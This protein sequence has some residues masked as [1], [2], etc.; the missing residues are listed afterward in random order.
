LE[1][2]PQ[3]IDP[4]KTELIALASREEEVNRQVDD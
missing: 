2:T 1:S 3:L 4:C